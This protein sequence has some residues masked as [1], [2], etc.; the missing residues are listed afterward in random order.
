MAIF[1]H[2]FWPFQVQ[3]MEVLY[4]ISS[5]IV[6]IFPQIALTQA[7]YIVGGSNLGS[8]TRSILDGQFN[9]NPSVF[10][11]N[12]II[13]Y[14]QK[15]LS[16]FAWYLRLARYH[17]ICKIGKHRDYPLVNEQFAIEN[18]PVE[19]VD[20][21]SYKMFFFRNLNVYQRVILQVDCWLT[22]VILPFKVSFPI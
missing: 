1:S 13:Q 3:K 7:L 16:C 8:R 18:S 5:Y 2:M 21:P 4:H 15:K 11:I 12:R 20:L 17:T 22:M 14:N 10:S 19:I 9:V 6:G